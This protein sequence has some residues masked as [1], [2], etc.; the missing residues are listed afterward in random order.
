M[1]VQ[2]G[3]QVAQLNPNYDSQNPAVGAAIAKSV[4]NVRKLQ[5]EARHEFFVADDSSQRIYLWFPTRSAMALLVVR[6]QIPLGAAELLARNLIRYGDGQ[7]IDDQALEA[8]FR[9]SPITPQPTQPTGVA[10]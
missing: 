1:L 8:A 2:C 6:A 7:N 10:P 5:P 9:A 4:G 3:L